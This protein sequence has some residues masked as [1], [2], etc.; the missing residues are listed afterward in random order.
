MSRRVAGLAGLLLLLATQGALANAPRNSP[1]P[2][3]RPKAPVGDVLVQAIGVTTPNGLTKLFGKGPK[4]CGVKGIQGKPIAPIKGTRKGCGLKDGVEITAVYGVRLSQP[5]RI[6]CP[7][8][9]ALAAWVDQAVKPLIGDTG[10]GLAEV[11][12][13]GHYACRT[14]N[15][16]KG[17]KVSEHG[18]GR[19]VDIGGFTLADGTRIPV[20]SG[21]PSKTHGPAMKAAHKAACGPFG[22][23][24]GPRA[25]RHHR[26]HFHLDTA[27]YRSGP[28]CK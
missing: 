3:P 26:D 18:K 22:T 27:R 21:W 11:Q 7:T 4:L 9:R 1:A 14:R 20:L 19:A 23:V 28:Y 12:V 24:L 17:A 2:E 8:A 16:K 15:N 13:I 10:G 6:D 25:N 5:A